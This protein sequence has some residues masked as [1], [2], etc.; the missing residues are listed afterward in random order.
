MVA[1]HFITPGDHRCE[2]WDVGI[3]FS[4]LQSAADRITEH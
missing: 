2:P 4:I 3:V 1:Q